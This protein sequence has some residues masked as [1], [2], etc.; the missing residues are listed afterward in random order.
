MDRRAPVL[1]PLLAGFLLAMPYVAHAV[2]AAAGK[3]RL[4]VRAGGVTTFDGLQDAYGGGWSLTLFFTEKVTHRFLVDIRLGALYLGDLKF[5]ELD[6]E[7]THTPGIQGAMRLLYFSVGPMVG[8]PLGGPWSLYGSA[9]L[10]VYSVS[11]QFD[12]G[13][14]AYNFSDQTF[15]FNGGLGLS[16]R[17][18]ANW[19]IEANASAHYF[20][21]DQD[22]TDL[23]FAFTGGADSPVLLDIA[24]GVTLDLR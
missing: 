16:R 19:C 18:S 6:D 20:L 23:F 1:V 10:G 21:T 8:V 24:L 22:I 9:G 17:I 4:G 15:G 12:T 13:I 14:S 2:D 5:S 11:M 7:L 3:D